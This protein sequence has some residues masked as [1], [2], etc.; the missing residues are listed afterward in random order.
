L[1]YF[2]KSK[3]IFLFTDASEDAIEGFLRHS[4]A[5]NE[6]DSREDLKNNLQNI[7]LISF[8]AKILKPLKKTY[9]TIEK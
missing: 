9:A 3:K 7:Y 1:I 6:V 8:F 4:Y 2:D 5:S